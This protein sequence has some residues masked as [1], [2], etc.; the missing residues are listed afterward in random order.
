V[1]DSLAK[2]SAIASVV[3][4]SLIGFSGVPIAR[5]STVVFDEVPPHAASNEPPS[6]TPPVVMTKFRK[7]SLRR[8][9]IYPRFV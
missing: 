8:I 5:P 3:T 1:P 2:P 7:K 9:V 4:G 6:V